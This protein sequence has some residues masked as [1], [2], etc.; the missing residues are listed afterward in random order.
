MF[1]WVEPHCAGK[2]PEWI[3]N[4]LEAR[5]PEPG[6]RRAHLLDSRPWLVETC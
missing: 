4:R 6:I 1:A 2:L 5:P 3:W